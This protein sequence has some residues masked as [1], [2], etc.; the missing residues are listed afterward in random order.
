MELFNAIAAPLGA[1]LAVVAAALAFRLTEAKREKEVQVAQKVP[2]LLQ[3]A[4]LAQDH[5]PQLI[6]DAI[7][8]SVKCL[9]M[10]FK[11]YSDC[12]REFERANRV[13]DADVKEALTEIGRHLSLIARVLRDEAQML[14]EV[15]ERRLSHG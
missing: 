8:D 2:S 9:C 10:E 3:V 12:Q 5:A 6:A 13:N 11:E 14:K 1:I 15:K 7:T 4:T